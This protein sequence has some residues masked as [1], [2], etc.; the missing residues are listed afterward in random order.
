MISAPCP[1]CRAKLDKQPT[2]KKAC[3]HCGQFIF[4]RK[5]ELVTE[6][7]AQIRDWLVRLEGIGI[8]RRMFDQ[9]RKTLD[10]KFGHP[11]KAGDVVW[12]LLNQQLLRA[13]SA[14][15]KKLIHLEMAHV[16]QVEGKDPSPML[17]EAARQELLNYQ[18]TG[19]KKVK[20][21]TANDQH[22]CPACQA[23]AKRVFSL[24]EALAAMP[25]PGGCTS[26]HGCRCFYSPVF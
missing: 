16:L 9:E 2:R 23:H 17:T 6:G 14:D 22:V 11:A 15:D 3:P 12:G 19:V 10:K 5:G 8:T 20:I 18:A 21:H 1:Y 24:S 7:E 4:V 26:E 25:I 13:I